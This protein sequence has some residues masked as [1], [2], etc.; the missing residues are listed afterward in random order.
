[1]GDETYGSDG[2]RTNFLHDERGK[3]IKGE[4]LFLNIYTFWVCIHASGF[5]KVNRRYHPKTAKLEKVLRK[6]WEKT[7]DLPIINVLLK[8]IREGDNAFNPK[9]YLG[10]DE[11]QY[12]QN[13][14]RWKI[15]F[16]KLHLEKYPFLTRVP[17][18]HKRILMKAPRIN[19]RQFYLFFNEAF[20]NC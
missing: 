3:L 11:E 5:M 15:D 16:E 10:K 9:D 12:F 8:K 1:M 19:I 17:I 2:F 18:R 4:H 7:K 13:L 20:S 6:K 14:Q